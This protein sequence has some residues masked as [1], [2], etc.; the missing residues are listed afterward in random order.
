MPRPRLQPTNEQRR[1]VKSLAA[2]GVPQVQIAR[3]VGVRSEK[4]L[5]KHFR[6]ELDCGATEANY[7]VAQSLFKAAI[8]GDTKAAMFW[9][10]TR[11]GW[12][13]P[14][15]FQPASIQPPPFIVSQDQGGQQQ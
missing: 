15:A 6:E 7:N 12:R 10:R 3:K 5:R 8:A 9:L 1:L 13:D 11:A 2:C 14:S 4:T